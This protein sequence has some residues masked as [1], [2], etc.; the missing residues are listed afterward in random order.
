[1]SPFASV[2]VVAVVVVAVVVL[3]VCQMHPSFKITHL[4]AE[5]ET[6]AT[7]EEEKRRSTMQISSPSLS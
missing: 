3:G 2:V 6:T 4:G 7:S 5:R 1:M